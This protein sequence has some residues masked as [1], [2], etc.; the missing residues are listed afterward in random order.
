[1]M[2]AK[3]QIL[4]GVALV[5][6]LAAP[7]WASLELADKSACLNCHQAEKK[8]VGP[9][10]NDIAAK[11]KDR[12]DAAVYLTEKIVKGSTGAWG[13]IP[14]PANSQ[15]SAEDAK[16]LATWVLSLPATK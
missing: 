1:M 4:C 15:L 14:M 7:A 11:Y 9:A 13:A 5:S 12:K 8:M 10:L 16:A 3:L 6:T 2:A